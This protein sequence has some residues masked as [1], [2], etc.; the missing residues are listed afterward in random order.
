MFACNAWCS[1]CFI[2]STENLYIYYFFC[3]YKAKW[4]RLRGFARLIG[5]GRAICPGLSAL[6]TLLR[7][8]KRKKLYLALLDWCKPVHEI[9]FSFSAEGN[10]RKHRLGIHSF[11]FLFYF[12]GFT[13]FLLISDHTDNVIKQQSDTILFSIF[14]IRVI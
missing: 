4:A 3:F 1:H 7:H 12:S 10:V 9:L 13:C 14:G 11:R 2:Y 8:H 5:I 6:S